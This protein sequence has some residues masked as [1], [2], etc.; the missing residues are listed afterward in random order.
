MLLDEMKMKMSAET[1]SNWFR[2]LQLKW[3]EKHK[4]IIKYAV[5][6]EG[7][8]TQVLFCKEISSETCTGKYYPNV[9]VHQKQSNR[10]WCKNIQEP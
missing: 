5:E 10:F 6:I 8:Y 7:T 3:C 2:W 9:S 4:Q 1:Q